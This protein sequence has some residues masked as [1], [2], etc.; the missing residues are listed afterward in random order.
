MHQLLIAR[1]GL[2]ICAVCACTVNTL[3]AICVCVMVL[4]VGAGDKAL[5][6][7]YVWLGEL[8]SDECSAVLRVSAIVHRFAMV[9]DVFD[10]TANTVMTKSIQQRPACLPP[11]FTSHSHDSN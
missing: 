6:L 1:F 11:I 8:L 10:V 2:N 5:L 7:L 4:E 3:K 9:I